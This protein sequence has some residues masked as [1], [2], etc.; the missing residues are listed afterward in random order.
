MVLLQFIFVQNHGL[1]I[2]KLFE[3]QKK[4]DDL[5]KGINYVNDN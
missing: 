2:F 5:K 1:L 4:L 3:Y